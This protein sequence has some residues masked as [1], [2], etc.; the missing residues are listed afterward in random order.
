MEV[1]RIN[2][3]HCRQCVDVV[4]QAQQ[5][6]VRAV[7]RDPASGEEQ[8]VTGVRMKEGEKRQAAIAFCPMCLAPN[9]LWYKR[10]SQVGFVDHF[11]KQ[12]GSKRAKN[13]MVFTDIRQ[14]PDIEPYVMNAN[15]PSDLSES[16][17][18]VLK[19]V[20]AKVSPPNIAAAIG[21]CLEIACNALNAG[22]KKLYLMIDALK[23]D[24]HITEPMHAWAHQI[25]ILRNSGTHKFVAS[26]SD[27]DAAVDFM[28][29]FLHVAFTLRLEIEAKTT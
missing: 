12:P 7:I 23:N 8:T 3:G 11:P 4:L 2:C 25:R 29:I 6:A 28:K 13:E 26:N 22:G 17:G 15:W 16:W 24:G 27:V 10:E 5:D 18:D 20:D 9:L 1:M 19:M 21:V 14:Y